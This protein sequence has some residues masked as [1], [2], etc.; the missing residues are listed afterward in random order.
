MVSSL[1]CGERFVGFLEKLGESE[2][3]TLLIALLLQINFAQLSSGIPL[4]PDFVYRVSR[5][6]VDVLQ[7]TTELCEM[8]RY[9]KT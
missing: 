3:S 4:P 7:Q 6:G 1:G 9:K 5:S 2:N 8:F